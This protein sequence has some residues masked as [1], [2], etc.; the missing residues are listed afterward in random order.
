MSNIGFGSAA[1]HTSESI[2][3]DLVVPMIEMDF[4]L[5]HPQ[6]IAQ[7]KNFEVSIASKFY[8]LN[9]TQMHKVKLFTKLIRNR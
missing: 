7:H 9:V 4:P 1:T 3:P 6:K 5:K 2:N 8:S